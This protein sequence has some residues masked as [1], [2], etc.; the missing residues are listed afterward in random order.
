MILLTGASASGKTEVA[1]LL[2]KKYGIQKV[3]T[4]TTREKRVGETDGVDY[5]FVD[6]DK[7]EQMIK[8]GE[9]VEY[10]TFN[11]NLYGSTKSQIGEDKCM[12]IEPVGLKCYINL[13]NP[14]IVTFY[15]EA[16]EEI[17]RIRMI[18]RGDEEGKIKSRLENDRI[19]FSKENIPE[20][21]YRID[22]GADK[23][24]EAVTDLIYKIYNDHFKK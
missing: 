20:V 10:T 23:S 5:F 6:R 18:Q 14:S 11:G 2:M 24:I 17:R 16:D 21:D 15:L 7:F 19:A 4:T 1:K 3:I 12:V 13:H 8:N 22:S 9:F